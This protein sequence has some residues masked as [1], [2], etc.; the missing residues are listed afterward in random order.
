MGSPLYT[1]FG[2]AALADEIQSLDEP[3]WVN[4]P[5]AVQSWRRIVDKGPLVKLDPLAL[6]FISVPPERPSA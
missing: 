6:Y 3:P 2:G 1:P 4:G 5:L